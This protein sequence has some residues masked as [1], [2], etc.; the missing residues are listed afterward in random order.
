MEYWKT[1]S[2]G[3]FKKSVCGLLVILSLGFLVF[4]MGCGADMATRKKQSEDLRNLGEAYLY[5]GNATYALKELLKAQEAFADDPILQNDLGLAYRAKDRLDLAIDHFKR[6]VELD[7]AYAPARNNL[8][9]AYLLKED[10]DAAIAALDKLQ[11]N[12]LYTTPHFTHINL[13]RA[14]FGKGEYIKAQEYY[15]LAVKHYEDGFAKDFNYLKA[16]RGLGQTYLA[17]GKLLEAEKV[18][19]QAIAAA[20]NLA[21]LHFEMARIY[22]QARKFHK[23]QNSY[24]RVIDLDPDSSLAREAKV[25]LEKLT[26]R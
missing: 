2:N 13:G 8:G 1:E 4:S 9:E 25:E 23:A 26:R 22:V 7:P 3:I 21:P 14:Y 16:L 15:Q 18:I 20:P 5:K 17:Q 11:D 19:E 6:A 12:L 10:W 24:Q